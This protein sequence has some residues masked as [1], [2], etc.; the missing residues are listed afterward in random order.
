MSEELEPKVERKHVERPLRA[1]NRYRSPESTAQLM[2]VESDAFTVVFTEPFC[3]SCGVED[4]FDD[5][6]HEP[7]ELDRPVVQINDLD[8]ITDFA[9]INEYTIRQWFVAS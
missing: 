6:R 5:P 4:Y 8:Q 2:D 9:Y 7:G 3:R 1:L